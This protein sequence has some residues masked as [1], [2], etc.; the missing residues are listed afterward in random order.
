MDIVRVVN[1]NKGALFLTLEDGS[2]GAMGFVTDDEV[3]I[4]EPVLL[5]CLAN[6]LDG[7]IR[8]KHHA[9]VGPG[10]AFL[11]CIC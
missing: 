7:V 2:S 10:V 9:H 5:L 1:P 8:R 11:H 3:E 4:S 6:D